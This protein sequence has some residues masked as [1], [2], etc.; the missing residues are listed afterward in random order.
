MHDKLIVQPG[1]DFKFEDHDPAFTAAFKAE[2]E[3]SEKLAHD[4]KHMTRLQDLLY[5]EKRHALLIILQAMDAAG[6]DGTIKHVMSGVNP[7]G[8]SVKSFKVPSSEELQHDYLWRAVKALP[9][10]GFIGIFNRSYYEELIVVRV[11]PEL[12][13]A[14]HVPAA[15]KD[16]SIWKTRYQ[17]INSFEK[18]LVDNGTVILKF[19][20]NLSKQEQRKRLL[21]RLETPAKNWKFSASDLKERAFWDDYIQAYE[22]MLGHTSTEWAPWYIIP[23]DHKWFSRVAVADAIVDKLASLNLAYPELT[24]EDE[25]ELHKAKIAL[26]SEDSNK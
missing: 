14:E 21:S 9:E 16:E 1:K 17:E 10:R 8:C 4:L 3:A 15:D 7:Q 6:K 11:H 13:R 12:L 5:A 19:F 22:K 23:A 26:E 2:E 25:V 18:Y 20:L 24:T